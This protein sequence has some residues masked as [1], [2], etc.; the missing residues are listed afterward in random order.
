MKERFQRNFVK[1]GLPC[2]KECGKSSDAYALRPDG[3]GYCFGQCGGR[4]FFKEGGYEEDL[5]QVYT[6]RIYPHRGISEKTFNRFNV[7]TKF[8]G[9]QPESV[10]FIYPNNGI[11]IRHL[12]KPKSEAFRTQG[13]LSSPNLFLKNYFDRGSRRCITVVEGEYDALAASEILQ[14][15]SAVVSVRNASAALSD[16]KESTNW[17]YVNSFE[18]IIINFDND[19]AGQEAAKKVLSLFDFK[20]TYNLCLDK[21]K[22]ANS[23]LYDNQTGEER[24][25]GKEYYTA[26][27]GVRRFTPDNILSGNNDFRKALQTKR[28]KPLAT[29]PLEEL[30]NKLYG[31]HPGEVIIVKALEKIG[32]TEMF[33]LFE[34]H[35]IKTTKINI[36]IIHLEE[37]NGTTLRGL[38]A[39][40]SGKPLHLPEN[41]DAEEEIMEV[42]EK[43]NGPDE[44]RIHLRSSFDMEDED[45]FINGIRFMISGLDCKI[46]MLDH[47]SWLATGGDD[48]DERKKL[49]RI[50]TRIKLLAKELGAAIIMIS[51]VNDNNQTRGS[52]YITKVGDTIINIYRDKVNPDPVERLKTVIEIE[53]ARLMGATTGP[54]GYA[55]YDEEVKILKD[56]RSL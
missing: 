51:H 4:N 52:R 43:I 47:I 36:G 30:Q 28:S 15:E 50:A 2:P 29:Y 14:N 26:W 6:A 32:K 21:Y 25:E 53:G 23:Y 20:K 11:K 16:L 1:S 48:Q 8:N 17:D 54:A 12:N 13:D 49:D 44:S 18:K 39:Y 27:K 9:D 22:D 33:R 24:H 35:I 3:S 19:T 34:D 31:I 38:A 56:P 41:D 5:S 45:T 10:G 37:D 40:Y 55:I 46:I 7:Q 42:I